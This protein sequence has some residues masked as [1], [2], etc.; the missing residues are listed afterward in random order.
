M[1]RPRKTASTPIDAEDQ[2][3][4]GMHDEDFPQ[5]PQPAKRGPGRPRKSATPGA[6]KVTTRRPTTRAARAGRVMTRAQMVDKVSAEMYAFSSMLLVAWEIRDPECA[7][8]MY[9][10]VTIPTPNGMVADQRLNALIARTV[11]IIA[12]DEKRL[13]LLAKSGMVGELIGLGALLVPIGKQVWRHHGPG[14]AGHGD[15]TEMGYDPAQ[16]P[17]NVG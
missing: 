5:D 4:P 1:P 14:A 3:L 15:Q 10:Q 6:P 12:R 16:Y 2:N 13:E 7:S 11:A 17:A 8:V 9:D